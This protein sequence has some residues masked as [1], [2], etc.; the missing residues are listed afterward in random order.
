MP[1][2]VVII[3]SGNVSWHLAESFSMQGYE[4]LQVFS[5]NSD[6]AFYFTEFKVETFVTD[7]KKIDPNAD[8]YFICVNDDSIAEIA[9]QLLFKLRDDQILVHTSGNCDSD[10]L[11]PYC[12]NYGCFWPV[13]TLRR[14]VSIL[15][16]EIPIIITASNDFTTAALVQM[17]DQISD[18]FD[19]IDDVSKSKLH[20]AAVLVNN[21]S[22]HLYTLTTE[23]CE[24]EGIDFN[25][26]IPLIKETALKLNND[27][28]INVQTGPAIRND[29][30]TIEKQLNI[31]EKYPSLYK[32]YCLFTESI[33][34]KYN[35]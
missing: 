13:Q 14:D 25:I 31:L 34:K 15:T 6:D 30:R 3:G 1:E 27:D 4:I 8:I 19:V 18:H 5:R 7:I 26:L 29:K 21:F 24:S 9:S 2:T 28:P 16:N 33:I 10:I 32:M 11:K 22:N 17:A 35:P 12:T 23:F 20:V